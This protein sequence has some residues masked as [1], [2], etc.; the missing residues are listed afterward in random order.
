M[1]MNKQIIRIPNIRGHYSILDLRQKLTKLEGVKDVRVD[2][3]TKQA[4]I[5][6]DEPATWDQ[7]KTRLIEIDYP[8]EG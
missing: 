8:V 6:W 7:I 5:L 2:I 4:R 3:T 1:A